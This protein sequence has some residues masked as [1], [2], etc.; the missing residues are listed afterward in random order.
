MVYATLAD[1]AAYLF[2]VYLDK[3]ESLAPGAAQAHVD[4]VGAEID[5][6]LAP[7]VAL[8]LPSV[9]ATLRRVNAVIAAYRI[10]GQ[11]TT[12][13]TTEASSA[14]EWI[15]LQQQYKQ[16][17]A[18]LAD[19]RAGKLTGLGIEDGLDGPAIVASSAPALFDDARWGRF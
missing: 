9:P 2:Q 16:A 5:A 8:P 7:H 12:L 13:V 18:E 4:A 15:P 6:A 10:V 19:I 14:N 3:I 17:M 1:V 11:I